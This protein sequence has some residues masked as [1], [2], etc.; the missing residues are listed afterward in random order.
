MD[1]NELAQRLAQHLLQSPALAANLQIPGLPRPGPVPHAP[2]NRWKLEEIGIFEP[3]LPVDERHPAG[4]VI[5]VGRDTIYRNVDAF[6]ERILDAIS[7]KGAELVRDNLQSCLRG[8]AIR[9]FTHEL[10]AIDKRAIRGD[11]TEGL[12]QWIT[13]LQDR[14]RPRMAQA[15]RENNELFFR[16]ADVRAGKR[17]IHYFQS[18]LLRARAAGYNTV[19]AQLI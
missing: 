7:S 14:F 6:C 12:E 8:Q 18:K 13:R 1:M 3:D 2:D 9:W 5:T 10:A 16:I 11:A 15:V 17:L 4:D 19:H